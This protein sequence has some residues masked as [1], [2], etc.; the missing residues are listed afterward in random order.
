MGSVSGGAKDGKVGK[1]KPEGQQSKLV[2]EDKA[3]GK[4]VIFRIGGNKEE[5]GRKKK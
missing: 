5:E 1:L 2:A 3:G 4:G